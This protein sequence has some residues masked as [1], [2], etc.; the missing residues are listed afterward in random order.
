MRIAIVNDLPLAVEALRRTLALEADYELAWVARS[1]EE[2]VS[3]CAR[4]TP[5]LVLLDLLMPGI[6]GVEATRQ[7]M[8]RSP[9]AILIATSYLGNNE[10]RVFE[11][12]GHGALDV[13]E[14]PA[15]D[16][17]GPL[18]TRVLAKLA[19][20]RRLIRSDSAR[21]R[22]RLHPPPQQRECLLAI[23][24]SAGGP[25]ALATLLGSLP[26]TTAAAIVIVQHVD[27]QFAPGMADWLGQQSAWPVRVAS[28]G[29]RVQAGAALLAG[30][31]DHLI[32]K[33]GDR[34]GYTPDPVSQAYRPSIDVF[35]RAL[36]REWRGS[37]V[38][39]LLTGMG[40][41]GA[42]GLKAMRDKGHHTIAQDE[43]S[44]AVFGM[45]KAAAQ[46]H[47]A[48]EI[49]P[50]AAISRRLFERIAEKPHRKP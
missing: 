2:A 45:P 50:L 11:A 4:D 34:L 26:L 25:A 43:A 8:E 6:G 36:V 16:A 44:S 48:S 31:S 27:A 18:V 35:F 33:A 10:G 9:C 19:T 13:V 29:D 30:T 28:E 47:A 12:M 32:L 17:D 14:I 42:S 37:A 49:L 41:D 38:G 46:L 1:G 22:S 3:M 5:D 23:G 20:L 24:A 21:P 7:I 15:L 40:R 39:V